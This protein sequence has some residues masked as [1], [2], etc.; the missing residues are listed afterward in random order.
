MRKYQPIVVIVA[1][2]VVM[3]AMAGP[4]WAQDAE[5]AWVEDFEA[6]DSPQEA[7]IF[8]EPR[9]S[10][11]SGDHLIIR[12]VTNGA[13]RYG[14]KYEPGRARDRLSMLWGKHQWWQGMTTSW[15]PFDLKQYP[16]LEIC[17]QGDGPL[18]WFATTSEAG[19]L[20][21]SYTFPSHWPTRTVIDEQG[22]VVGVATAVVKEAENVGFAIP[23][24]EAVA[25]LQGAGVVLNL[26]LG[27][28]SA[29]Q[30]VKPSPGPGGPVVPALPPRAAQAPLTVLIL[31]GVP[32]VVAL[33]VS[34]FV[35]LLVTCSLRRR[36]TAPDISLA[37][38]PTAAA[39]E[40]EDLS[41]IDIEL[42]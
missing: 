30:A 15:G 10:G 19:D 31:V 3:V 42:H 27:Q 17:W 4:S 28:H 1:T 9:G 22:R 20:K 16:L 34:L 40:E 38:P 39:A 2:V 18:V 5:V 8:Y 11:Q 21:S 35:S 32:L 36:L 24:D 13:L 14:L 26:P 12:E 33:V 25:F 41:D 23:S 6:P 7:R 29:P 37:P